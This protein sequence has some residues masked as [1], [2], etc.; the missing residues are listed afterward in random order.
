MTSFSISS[1]CKYLLTVAIAII[2]KA[3]NTYD[4]SEI[5]DYYLRS[6]GKLASTVSNFFISIADIVMHAIKYEGVTYIIQ[7]LK[8]LYDSK[9]IISK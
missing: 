2:T 3:L 4:D 7:Y 5:V 9:H 1:Y 8:S 6:C